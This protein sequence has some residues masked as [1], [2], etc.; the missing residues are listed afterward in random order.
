M[1][2]KYSIFVQNTAKS[3]EQPLFIESVKLKE[4]CDIKITS[5]NDLKEL[6]GNDKSNIQELSDKGNRYDDKIITSLR[7]EIHPDSIYNFKKDFL[8]LSF[9]QSEDQNSLEYKR[10]ILSEKLMTDVTFSLNKAFEFSFQD[11]MKNNIIS[12]LARNPKDQIYTDTKVM[13]DN[14]IDNNFILNLCSNNFTIE[15]IW[16]EKNEEIMRRERRETFLGMKNSSDEIENTIMEDEIVHAKRNYFPEHVF[17]ISF[18]YEE[19]EELDMETY[20][21]FVKFVEKHK[22]DKISAKIKLVLSY[23]NEYNH[24]TGKPLFTNKMKN[25]KLHYWKQEYDKALE[26]YKKQIEEKK[27]QKMYEDMS[28][29]KNSFFGSRNSS[30]YIISKKKNNLKT[31]LSSGNIDLNSINTNSLLSNQSKDSRL[32]KKNLY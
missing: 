14:I 24:E 31:K 11:K 26:M 32:S 15:D 5:P 25:E 4:F 23:I 19:D 18:N 9:D 7:N 12:T 8:V 13:D 27:K 10:K 29:R 22:N 30:P 6:D 1:N 3:N 20:N 17:H 2:N 28:N 16:G 21:F